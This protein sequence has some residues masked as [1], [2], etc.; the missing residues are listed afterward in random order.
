M[1]ADE[2]LPERFSVTVVDGV[3]DVRFTRPE[4]RNALDIAAFLGIVATTE[5]LAS[6]PSVRVVVLSGEGAAFCSGIDFTIF[7]GGGGSD[8]P[9]QGPMANLLG[10]DDGDVANL[11]QKAAW[12]WHALPQPVIAAVHGVAYGG[13]FQIAVACDLRIAHPETT[14]S[15][16]ETKWGL[17]PDM[18]GTV[19]LPDLVGI[20]VAKELTWTGRVFGADEAS[21]LG[22]VTRI[23]TDPLAEALTLAREIAHRSPDA[24]RGAKRLFDGAVVNDPV[25]QLRLEEEVQLGIIGRPNQ[26]EAIAAEFQKRTPNFTDPS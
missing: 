22:L 18:S 14:F 4:K 10:R 11:A 20:D 25:T 16:M 17:V 26:F 13:G 9:S 23:A 19:F 15:I 7:S 21:S 8:D 24:V 6:D 3:A 12:C 1:A 5:R 2:P